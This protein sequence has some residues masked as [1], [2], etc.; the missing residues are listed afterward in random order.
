VL[1]RAGPRRAAQEVGLRSGVTGRRFELGAERAARSTVSLAAPALGPPGAVPEAAAQRTLTAA[2]RLLAG[3]ITVFGRTFPLDVAHGPRGDWHCDPQSEQR[4]PAGR[5]WWR[6]DVRGEDRPG[7]VKWVWEAAR[8]R[9]LVVLARAAHLRPED[10]RVGGAVASVITGWSDAV[11][12]ERSVHWLSNLELALRSLSWLQALALAPHAIEG[13]ALVVAERELRVVRRHLELGLARTRGSMPNN[14]LVGD[15]V[16]LAVLQQA[17]GADPTATDQHLVEQLRVEVREDGSTIEES[18]SYHRF[19][20]ELLA[21][22]VLAG[23]APPEVRKAV[24]R[25]AR[26]LCRLGVLEG[27]TPQHAAWVVGRAIT[28]EGDVHDLA[29]SARLGL[30]LAGEGAPPAWRAQHDE[31]AWHA[32][33]GTPLAPELPEVDGWDLGGG[34]TRTSVGEWTVWQ[35]ASAGGWHGHAD[36]TGVVVHHRGR[37]VVGDPGTGAYNGPLEERTWFRSSTAHAV[38]RLDGEDQ[39]VPHRQFRWRNRARAVW[40]IPLHL[41]DGFVS[42]TG[43][44]AYARLE[45]ARRTA[46]TAWVTEAGVV[47]ADWVDPSTGTWSLSLPLHPDATHADGRILLPGGPDLHLHLP[48]DATVVEH[49]GEAQPLDGWWS[50]TYGSRVPATRLAL[51]GRCTPGRPIVWAVTTD[52]E[53]VEIDEAGTVHHHGAELRVE[54][55]ATGSDVF[56]GTGDQ[57]VATELLWP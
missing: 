1:G 17:F 46:R 40:A 32:G 25:L 53:G 55:G 51:E 43:H 15:L 19:V 52:G 22:R 41:P 57:G 50:A 21:L 2:D 37:I 30:A 33:D 10:R 5:P 35:R 49:R 44:D 38:L 31:V 34:I 39:L 8:H 18:L 27:E 11:P 20:L 56:V 28:A 47:I 3:E 29:G 6:I 26:S 16:G 24:G 42:V 14:H 7:D 12:L 4:W 23:G 54:H 45:P 36:H 48:S 13:H 9:H